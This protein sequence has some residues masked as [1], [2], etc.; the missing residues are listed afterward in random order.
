VVPPTL[1]STGIG[2]RKATSHAADFEAT[3]TAPKDF[4]AH[5]MLP[6]VRGALFVMH[7]RIC[8]YCNSLL[9]EY[10]HGEVEHFRPKGN[11]KEDI[12][13][14]GYWWLAYDF[15]NYILA[16]RQCNSRA[17]KGTSFPLR[18]HDALRL[19]YE[20]RGE[21][22]QEER[23]LL[24]PSLDPI[25]GWLICTNDGFLKP[26]PRLPSDSSERLTGVI[27]F[28][29]L[30]TRPELVRERARLFDES[31][32]LSITGDFVKLQ[33]RSLP[34]TPHS[35]AP[36]TVLTTFGAHKAPTVGEAFDALL[37]ALKDDF[38]A[39]LRVAENGPSARL[40]KLL[41]ELSYALANA[42][43]CPVGRTAEDVELYLQRFGLAEHL[44]PFRAKLLA[45]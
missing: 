42:W 19:R 23:H 39:A 20:N 14:G 36:L 11:L 12:T 16:C 24:D 38:I 45:S 43:V 37:D 34:T 4:P 35:V 25:D 8:G 28:F 27:E 3:G 6:D 32:A 33:Y 17:T 22:E 7:W 21:W 44:G 18:R 15:Q 40:H 26:D 2:G 10:D 41:T 30:N 29:R 5:W 13:H 9:N 1:R 31:L